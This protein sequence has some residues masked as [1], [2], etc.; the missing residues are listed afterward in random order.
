MEQL[1]VLARLDAGAEGGEQAT[2]D[3]EDVARSVVAELMPF[4]E[5]REIKVRLTCRGRPTLVPVP[6]SVLAIAIRNLVDNAVRHTHP[7]TE[8]VVAVKATGSETRVE[9]SDEGP[10]VP[11]TE[12]AKVRERFY[13]GAGAVDEGSGLGLSIVDRIAERYGLRL[14]LDNK[15][16][17]GLVA[18]LLIRSP[19]APPRNS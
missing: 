2:A 19:N 14:L 6:P 10:G 16:P 15:H 4:A 17:T 8:V 13:R 5:A 12:L 11:E 9:V 7:G 18:C 3:L 1:L